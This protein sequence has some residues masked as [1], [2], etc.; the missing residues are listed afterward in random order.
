MAAPA[1]AAVDRPQ[2][3]AKRKRRPLSVGAIRAITIVVALAIWETLAHSGL[4][5]K[6]VI[7][8][9]WKIVYALF[10]ELISAGF[11]HDLGITL[12]EHVVGFVSGSAL[13][14]AAGIALGSS[15]YIRRACEPYL[16][17]LGSTPKI[18]FLPIL[19]LV[20]GTGI[21]SKM[22]KGALSAFFPVIFA[23]IL[24]MLLIN[25]VHLRVGRSFNISWRHMIT[26]IYVPSMISPLMVGLK[27]GMAIAVTGVLVAEL[28]FANAGIGYRL[29]NYYDE[30][31]IAPLYALIIVCFS[32]AAFA[33]VGMSAVQRRFTRHESLDAETTEKL[34][35]Q[36]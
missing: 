1:V 12:S 16:N 33:H 5:Y 31:Q 2:Q 4:F 14:I 28:K 26:K 9:S 29:S 17:A 20:F 7:P 32:L 36:R 6:D 27:L 8:S 18:I 25:E 30:F 22:A 34:Q 15:P 10:E 23:T 21:E 19:F 13:A 11:Y 3:K 24:G 35:S